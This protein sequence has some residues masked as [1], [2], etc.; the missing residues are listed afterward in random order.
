MN[1]VILLFMVIAVPGEPPH[2][3]AQLMPNLETCWEQAAKKM[4]TAQSLLSEGISV[5]AGCIIH[6]SRKGPQS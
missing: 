2:Q 1:F 5:Q 3:A 6:P 4:A